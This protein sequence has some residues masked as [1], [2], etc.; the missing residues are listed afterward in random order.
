[1]KKFLFIYNASSEDDLAGKGDWMTW[2]QSISTHVVDIGSPFPGGTLVKGSHVTELSSMSDLVDG[3][4]LINAKNIEEA[5][6]LAKSS[7]SKAGVR[8]FEAVPK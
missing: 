5:A 8:I 4:S 7:P 1:M 6:T 3:Y 2:L